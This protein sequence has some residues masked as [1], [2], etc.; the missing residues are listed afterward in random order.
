MRDGVRGGCCALCASEVRRRR[1]HSARDAPQ[2]G[3]RRSAATT[4]TGR[5]FGWS[6][7][8]R[9]S[10]VSGGRPR[11]S[12][13]GRPGGRREIAWTEN[14]NTARWGCERSPRHS[15]VACAGAAPGPWCGCEQR[16]GIRLGQCCQRRITFWGGKVC[17]ESGPLGCDARA[18]G[19]P[20]SPCGRG[21]KEGLGMG[22]G[23]G[24]RRR[25]VASHVTCGGW[26]QL[27]GARGTADF[28][29]LRAM[30][31]TSRSHRRRIIICHPVR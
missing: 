21:C 13:E 27:P 29:G 12:A 5:Y 24:C 19:A 17:R 9:S 7:G 6:S 22:S 14:G 18:Q 8:P 10:S 11:T 2:R 4:D 20:A 16:R 26:R 30:M 3:V 28:T 31:S 25:L 15:R 23:A 1:Q